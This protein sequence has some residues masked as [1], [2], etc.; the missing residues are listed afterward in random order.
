[1]FTI[2]VVLEIVFPILFVVLDLTGAGCFPV[3]GET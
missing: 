3:I 1:M 2:P